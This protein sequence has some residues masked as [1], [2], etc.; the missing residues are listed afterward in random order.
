MQ[1]PELIEKTLLM[2]EATDIN[3]VEHVLEI[4]SLARLE[5]NKIL[6]KLF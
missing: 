5:T 6:N 1:I 2:A 4:D 3:S